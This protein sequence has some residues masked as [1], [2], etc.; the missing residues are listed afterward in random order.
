[1]A[2]SGK[3]SAL[4]VAR[5]TKKGMYGDGAGLWLQVRSAKVR[6][7]ILRY[8]LNGRARAMG[9]GSLDTVSLAD[10]R[11]RARRARQFLL[12]GVDPIEKRDAERGQAKLDARKSITFKRCA[13]LY[14]AAH[15]AG[16]RSAKHAT[17]WQTT[18]ETHA[19]PIIGDLSVQGI[20]TGLVVR[21]LEPIWTTKTETASRLRGRIEAV[22]NW[23]KTRGYR[24]G[25]NPA[26]WKGHLENLLPAPGKVRQTVHLSAL[27]Y[28]EIG[29][30]MAKLRAQEGV[31]A[32]ALEFAI[33][34]AGRTNEVL[35][36][37]F[38][39]IDAA[40]VWTIPAERMK[41]GRQH[42][43]PLSRAAL[44]IVEKI[45]KLGGEFIFPGAKAGKPISN[46]SM[47]I[48]LENM[49]RSDVTAHGFRSAFADWAAEQTNFPR[50]I[51]EMALAHVVGS[52]VERAYRRSDFFEKR[53]RLMDQWA[54]F[55]GTVAKPGKVVP[56]RRAKA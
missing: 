25:E 19:Y 40:G 2:Q 32:R 56:M 38:D 14:V 7:W 42:R 26:A 45:R 20:D 39:E 22:L 11:E 6:S 55:C 16:W 31:P 50:E 48:M 18:L 8:A 37:R 3:L 23:A 1:M 5:L 49:G 35:G 17:Q 10:A 27:P 21:V 54:T 29:T 51:A 34:T 36:A 4:K 41:G 33:L 12:D 13:E 47:L 24:S 43:V 53:R 44:A 52:E 9:L 15:R 28:S 30:F 46:N